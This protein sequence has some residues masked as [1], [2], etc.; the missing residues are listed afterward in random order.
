LHTTKKYKL[1]YRLRRRSDILCRLDY[2]SGISN[3]GR[4]RMNWEALGAIGE[5]LGSILVLAT[6]VYV[7]I[8]TRD[9]NKQ[10]QAEARYAFVD[11]VADINMIIAQNKQTASVWR[12]GLESAEDLDADERMQFFMLIGQYAN[13]WSVMHQLYEDNLLPDTQWTIVKNDMTSI[14]GSSGG[15]HFWKNGGEAGF[16]EVFVE[17]V[18]KELES[19]IRPYDMSRMTH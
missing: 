19:G 15:M 3:Y 2:P 4:Y 5:V 16:N 11:A 10:S 13:L 7:A 14:L 9:L 17:F 18:R 6:L 1:R 8:Q 12:R